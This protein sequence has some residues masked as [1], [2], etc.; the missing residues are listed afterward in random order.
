MN[1]SI[2]STPRWTPRSTSPA[3]ATNWW[4]SVEVGF[5]TRFVT[6]DVVAS[7]PHATERNSIR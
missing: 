7:S 4:N 2:S 1:L 5:A 3:V 6:S